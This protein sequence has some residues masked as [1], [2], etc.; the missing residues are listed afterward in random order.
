MAEWDA[1]Y[2][3]EEEEEEAGEAE[4]AAGNYKITGRDSLVFL[5]DAS[6][7]MFIKGEDG[8][9]SNFDMTMQVVRSVYTSKIISSHRD[10]I[11]LVFFGT[12][13]SKNPRNSFKHVYI[14]HD[15]D[16]PGARR[17]QDVD[18]LRGEKG[19][20]VAGETMGSGNT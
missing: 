17:V 7:E 5:V 6:K 15:L 1:Y 8:Q 2:H 10:L 18:G 13:Q 3:N 14:Y 9:P 20:Q 16:L 12:E 11:A 19:A 4:L